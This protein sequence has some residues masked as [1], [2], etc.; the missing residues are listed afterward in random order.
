MSLLILAKTLLMYSKP[1]LHSLSIP[2]TV[3]CLVYT[4]LVHSSLY[5]DYS[6]KSSDV[7]PLTYP[8]TGNQEPTFKKLLLK[9]IGT[10]SSLMLMFIF[11]LQFLSMTGSSQK[12]PVYMQ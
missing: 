8:G 4:T 10:G 9:K 5:I 7:F 12:T 6:L 3:N 1:N 2:K 11:L